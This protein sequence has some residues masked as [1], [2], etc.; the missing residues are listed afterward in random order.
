M[1]VVAENTGIWGKAKGAAESFVDL[2][3]AMR[4]GLFKG[5][6]PTAMITD[7]RNNLA[8]MMVRSNPNAN[9]AQ[10][11]AMIAKEANKKYST[12]PPA[13]SIFQNTFL[14]EVLRR[15]FFSVGESEGLLRQATGMFHGKH[16]RFWIKNNIG[17]YLFVIAVANIIHWA[18]TGEPLPKER[19]VPIAK[20]NW[21][22]LPFGYNQKFASPTLPWRG[23]G[24]VELTVDLVGQMDTALRVLDPGSFLSART[25][26]PIRAM[27]NQASG[28]DFYGAPIDDVGPGGLWS[29][30]TQL[31]FDLFS[32]IGVGGITTAGLRETIPGELIPRGEDRL[33]M[34]GLAIQST[35]INLRAEGTRLLLD[36]HA[37]KSG[38]LKADGS[39]VQ[40]WGDLEPHQKDK[41][42]ENPTLIDELALR[43][44]I[45]VERGYPG[46][47]GFW[48]LQDLD[49]R[50]IEKGEA[51]VTEFEQGIYEAMTFRN[52]VSRLKLEIASRKA[53]VDEDFQ[54]FLDTEE[55]P[56]DPNKRALAQY[57]SIFDN[58]KRLSGVIDWDIVEA[59]ESAF[60]AHWTPQQEAYVDRNTGLTKWGPKMQEYID[61]QKALSES[62]YWELPEFPRSIRRTF[63]ATN[64]TIEAILRKWYGYKPLKAEEV[65]VAKAP[66]TPAP[67]GISVE[68]ALRQL[69]E[70]RK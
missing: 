5:V 22:P 9:D 38:F 15:L 59:W 17:I 2:E 49:K 50:K 69:Q 33:G 28:T 25:S 67:G 41:V 13:Q 56:E 58:A 55:L 21:G 31:G 34:L 19:Y 35:G 61:A 29:R 65:P 63:R 23:R 51:L 44:E 47:L 43:S 57:Y 40:N 10:I 60:R 52:E 64:S 53:Q 7:I 68:E 42:L 6:Y 30:S 12:I 20:D 4:R 24:G 62:G 16:K 36:R 45:S 37:K 3:S 48:T 66:S 26:V 54:L 1:R 18:S 70:A 46:A 27:M 8:L 11:N 39:P 32:P 14:R